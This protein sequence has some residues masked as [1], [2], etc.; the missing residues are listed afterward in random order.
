L[1]G[2]FDSTVIIER[3]LGYL[4]VTSSELHELSATEFVEIYSCPYPELSG[5]YSVDSVINGN[6]F[7][8]VYAGGYLLTRGWATSKKVEIEKQYWNGD[9]QAISASSDTVTIQFEE[10]MPVPSSHD[11]L[12]LIKITDTGNATFDDPDGFGEFEVGDVT[13]SSDRRSIVFNVAGIGTIS[14]ID[15]T[16][17]KAKL[18]MSDSSFLL[19]K[20][21]RPQTTGPEAVLSL[22][23][24]A[25]PAGAVITHAYIL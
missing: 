1:E 18:N 17:A 16:P 3:N 19:I 24:F 14:E 10:P 22:A 12:G 2:G 4:T 21:L 23:S 6:S 13:I 15:E 7:K 8:V 9:I 20:T 5:V 11:I 25:K